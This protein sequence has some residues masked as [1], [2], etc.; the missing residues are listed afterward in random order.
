[1]KVAGNKLTSKRIEAKD[2]I[3]EVFSDFYH[4]R[5]TDGLPIIPPTEENVIKMMEYTDYDPGDVIAVLPP[6]NANATVEKIAINAVM[7]GCVPAYFPVVLTAVQAIAQKEFNLYGLLTTTCPAYPMLFV[8]GPIINELDF[9]VGHNAFG[10]GSRTNATIGR[11][12]TLIN[13]NI[14][15]ALPGLSDKSCQGQPGKYTY[16]FGENEARNPWEPYHVEQGFPKDTS[17]VTVVG[18]HAPGN[19]DDHES[20]NAEGFLTK[21]SNALSVYNYN[22]ENRE[23]V[24]VYICPEHAEQMA[25][26][27]WSKD[28]VKRFI[29]EN[30]RAPFTRIKKNRIY[31]YGWPKW[32]SPINDNALIRLLP[33]IEDIRVIVVGGAGKHSSIG[34]LYGGSKPV[35]MPIT[36]KDGTPI[37]SI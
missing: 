4:R 5:M 18:A 24:F 16:C 13:M 7:A 32:N 17:T 37:K 30:T 15:G 19:V 27:G 6:K 12:L 11:A 34:H 29:S 8:N 35:T 3:E 28:D 2:S 33:N 9:N 10:Q 22:I 36:K 26:E 14:S 21:F 23:K 1:M 31:T 20:T 25:K